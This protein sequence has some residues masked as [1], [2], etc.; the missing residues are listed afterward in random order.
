MQTTFQTLLYQAEGVV[1]Q[2]S[3]LRQILRTPAR[4]R[5]DEDV[6]DAVALLGHLPLFK[7]QPPE[8]TSKLLR[9]AVWQHCP[10]GILLP[11]SPASAYFKILR[12]FA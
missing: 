5:T 10:A 9:F 1:L 4:Q 8:V 3:R 6:K 2:L 7:S 12:I 11:W